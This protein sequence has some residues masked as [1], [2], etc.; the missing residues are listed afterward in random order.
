MHTY[1]C[2]S[3]CWT[4][5]I[6]LVKCTE[7]KLA[8]CPSSVANDYG[9]RVGKDTYVYKRVNHRV[10]V[11]HFRKRA[12]RMPCLSCKIVIFR[13]KCTALYIEK[14]SV[15]SN[16]I[17]QLFFAYLKSLKLKYNDVSFSESQ[18]KSLKVPLKFCAHYIEWLVSQAKFF[19]G[20]TGP[21]ASINSRLK[22]LNYLSMK[23]E[24]LVSVWKEKWN[25][26]LKNGSKRFAK[27]E[28]KLV[29]KNK[30]QWN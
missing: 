3:R 17:F 7:E 27:M 4:T 5:S 19:L 16:F 2:P 13:D 9:I 18:N 24:P 8:C 29:K 22:R 21:F 14:K 1:L 23:R 15:R 26:S 11:M 25:A 10:K 28:M 20:L 6:W 30:K 12:D